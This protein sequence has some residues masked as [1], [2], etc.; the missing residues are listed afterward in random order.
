MTI[1]KYIHMY[2]WEAIL[3]VNNI[4][5]EMGLR[6][7]KVAWVIGAATNEHSAEE[8]RVPRD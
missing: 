2:R 4:E 7:F 5:R 3:N 1:Y 6:K 8:F